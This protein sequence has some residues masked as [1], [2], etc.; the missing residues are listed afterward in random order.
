MM[1]AGLK[2]KLFGVLVL[3]LFVAS[4]SGQDSDSSAVTQAPGA[5][6]GTASSGS[7]AGG[8]DVTQG[9]LAAPKPGTQDELDRLVGSRV[10]FGYD[11]YDLSS[12]SQTVLRNQAN[13]LRNNPG[14]RIIIAGHCDERGT[15]EYN[16]ALGARRAESVRRYLMVLG[17][18][19]SR[20]RTISYG[21]ERPEM[22]ASNET[23]WSRNRRAVTLIE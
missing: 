14:K 3:T 19:G 10:Y 4:C 1:I 11:Q 13:W 9:T 16:L 12:A 5:G 15:R 2:P 23:S 21:K 22:A 6:S 8:S 18:D 7:G 17:V 20:V